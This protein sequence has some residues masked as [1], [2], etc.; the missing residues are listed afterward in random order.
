MRE[1]LGSASALSIDKE[2]DVFV[3]GAKQADVDFY[4]NATSLIGHGDDL[5]NDMMSATVCNSIS[6][7]DSSA[8]ELDGSSLELELDILTVYEEQGHSA[9]PQ[10]QDDREGSSARRKAH[11]REEW[12]R[13]QAT[14]RSK[15]HQ[16]QSEVD[17]LITKQSTLREEI[18]ALCTE[19]SHLTAQLALRPI[20]EASFRR[21]RSSRL[22]TRPPRNFKEED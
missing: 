6:Y 22:R 21:R 14:Y 11:R 13:R 16:L 4:A 18:E 2:L 17:C 1:P 3:L 9:V 15:R 5:Q 19:R 12:H 10:P 20:T 8:H 7:L